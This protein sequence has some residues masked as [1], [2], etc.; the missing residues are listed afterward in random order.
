MY[1]FID[2]KRVKPDD[3]DIAFKN[4]EQFYLWLSQNKDTEID[5]ISLDYYLD[6]EFVMH[7]NG[8]AIAKK[9]LTVPNPI[10]E[11]QIH[12]DYFE[13][14]KQIFKV[15][16]DAIVNGETT[17][18]RVHPYKMRMNDKG[19]LFEMEALCFRD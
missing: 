8:Y 19:E 4:A 14:G 13:G 7:E 16:R 11:I 18:R 5:L 15:I 3:F 12:S 10:Q 9:L 6:D 17:I 2:D 1:I